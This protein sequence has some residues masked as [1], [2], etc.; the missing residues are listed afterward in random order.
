MTNYYVYYR[1]ESKRFDEIRF[2]VEKI[3]T[4]IK[5]ETG[6]QGKWLR[7]R[8]DASTCMEVYEGVTDELAFEAVLQRESA[9]LNLERKIERFVSF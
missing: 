1:V 4:T 8:D 7:R 5:S 6:I 3:F 2:S 9:K